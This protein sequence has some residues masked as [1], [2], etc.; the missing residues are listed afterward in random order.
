MRLISSYKV[1]IMENLEL[2]CN[3][4]TIFAPDFE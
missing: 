4:P 2:I 1:I 3:F